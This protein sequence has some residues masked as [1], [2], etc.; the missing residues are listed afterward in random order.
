[1]AELTNGSWY[2]LNQVS[3]NEVHITG[4]CYSRDVNEGDRIKLGSS[5]NPIYFEI[6]ELSK[7]NHAGNFKDE[8][9]KINGFF[10]AKLRRVE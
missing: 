7:R 5:R 9:K 2:T 6:Y 1:M 3:Q 4:E 10:E 8:S